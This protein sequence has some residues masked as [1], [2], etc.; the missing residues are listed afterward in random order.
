MS[1]LTIENLH[2]NVEGKQ[3]LKGVNLSITN[4]EVVALLGPNGHGKSTQSTR[5]HRIKS[6]LYKIVVAKKNRNYI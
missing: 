4:G 6:Y 3:I 2:V 5:F 1:T